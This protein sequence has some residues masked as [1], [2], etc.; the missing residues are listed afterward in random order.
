MEIDFQRFA[1]SWQ[2]FSCS[3]SKVKVCVWAYTYKDREHSEPFVAYRVSVAYHGKGLHR[4]FRSGCNRKK[5]HVS[6]NLAMC[7]CG[8][9][10]GDVNY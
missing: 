3:S 4:Y 8:N 9:N 7:N 10:A 1:P 2:T 5:I 6:L